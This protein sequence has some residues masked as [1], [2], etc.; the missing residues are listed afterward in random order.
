MARLEQEKRRDAGARQAI[1][2]KALAGFRTIRHPASY[3]VWLSM[4]DEVRSDAVAMRLEREGILVSTAAPY[5][6]GGQPP[7]AIRLALGSISHARLKLA[8]EAVAGAVASLSY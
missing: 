5:A 8:L 6:M 4:P 7:H 1:A 2:A 3:F